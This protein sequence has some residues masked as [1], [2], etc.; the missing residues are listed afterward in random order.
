[1]FGRDGIAGLICLA[2]SLVLLAISFALPSVPLVPVGPGFYP[3]IVLAGMALFG[4][5]L[6]LQDW[7]ARRAVA[8]GGAAPA[9]APGPRPAYALVA[10]SFAIFG[11]Y[12]V[13]LPLLGYRIATVLFVATLQAQ[14]ERP[15]TP[16]GWL[17]LVLVAIGTSAI[18]W[19]VFERYLAV[20]LP[21]GTWT[22]W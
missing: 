8:A 3:R 6:V 17:A 18:T 19:L 10:L 20:L 4:A 7:R 15:A 11:L 21:R 5:L 22:G 9:E 2:V 13:L 12:V 14:L 16:R 1:M